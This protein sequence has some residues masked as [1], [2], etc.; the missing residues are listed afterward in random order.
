MEFKKKTKHIQKNLYNIERWVSYSIRFNC[1]ETLYPKWD[2]LKILKNY[3]VSPKNGKKI[4][5]YKRSKK[6]VKS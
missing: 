6:L 3:Q 2:T 1:A 4:K 5:V